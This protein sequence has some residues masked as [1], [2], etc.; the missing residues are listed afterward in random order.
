MKKSIFA[1]KVAEVIDWAVVV[2]VPAS[3]LLHPD[4]ILYYKTFLILFA[5]III[6]LLSF[7]AIV[8]WFSE[9][10]GQRIQGERKK[11]PPLGREIFG[12]SRAMFL[13]GA[14]AAWPTALALAGYPTGLAWTLEEMGLNWWQAVIQMYLGIVAIDAWT[15]WKHRFLHTRMFFPFHA[16]H[17]SFRDPTPFAGFAVG[18]VETVLTF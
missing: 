10:N 16:H 5:V 4:P 6:P 7:G 14:M 2:L 11:K 17:H 3:G 13:V 18:P 1:G 8:Y 12:T 15:Y 9:R